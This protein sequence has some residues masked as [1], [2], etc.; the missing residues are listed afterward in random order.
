[1]IRT[2]THLVTNTYGPRPFG[3]PDECFYCHAPVGSEHV[4]G[5]VMRQRTVIMRWT[6][7]IPI[8]VPEDWTTETIEFHDNDS[9]WCANNSVDTLERLRGDETHGCLC[10]MFS[11]EYLREADEEED[12]LVRDPE[13]EKDPAALKTQER[14]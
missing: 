11:A 1:M 14:P 3:R 2:K 9:S 5:C 10:H 8:S 13:L 7:E 6:Y 12:A 4:S